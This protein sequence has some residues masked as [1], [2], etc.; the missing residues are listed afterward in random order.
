MASIDDN[1]NKD[2]VNEEEEANPIQETIQLMK[3]IKDNADNCYQMASN[4]ITRLKDEELNTKDGNSLIELK[5]RMFLSYLMDLILMAM[6]KVSGER[7]E[8]FDAINRLVESRTV[9]ERMR[10]I[11]HKLKYSFDKLIKTATDGTVDPNDPLRFKPKLQS[12]LSKNDNNMSD[13]DMNEQNSDKSDNEK[14]G[15][16]SDYKKKHK[17]DVYV[18]PKVAQ[19]RFDEEEERKTKALQRAKMKAI[20]S[21]IINELRQE[22]DTRPEEVS[23][24]GQSKNNK[25]SQ[26]LNE[27][28]QFEEEFMTRTN[29]TKKQ[30]NDLKKA[31]TMSSLA[32]E[33]T[34]FEDITALDIE[35]TN[36]FQFTKKKKRGSKNSNKKFKKNN[37]K[38]K[39]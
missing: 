1:V 24:S 8:G 19:M 10:P 4:L 16:T 3:T 11:E 28:N 6:K 38:F 36:D 31:G 18:P 29:L 37:K 34:H 5:N 15:Q 14:S 9:L 13:E 7:L 2:N 27:K 22:F 32:N 21:S 33:L 25:M 35:D 23:H 17:S 39:K 26:F 20:N 30:K 12:I